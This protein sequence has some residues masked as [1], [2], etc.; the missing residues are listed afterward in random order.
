MEDWEFARRLKRLGRL[1]IVRMP[2]VS[3]WRAWERHG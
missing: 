3:S 2:A 1:E